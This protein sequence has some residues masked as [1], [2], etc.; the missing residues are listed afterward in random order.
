MDLKKY[1]LGRREGVR[2]LMAVEK[3]AVA[4]ILLTSLLILCFAG[5]MY[6]PWIMLGQR[7]GILAM[8]FVLKRIY[9]KIPCRLFEIVRLGAQL[10]LL[11]FWYPETY[12]FNKL[13]PNLDHIFASADQVLFACQPS[14]IFHQILSSKA[15]SEAFFM[16]YWSYY[17]M[18]VFVVLGYYFARNEK[19]ERASFVVVAS[20]FIYYIIYMFLPVAGPQYYFPA[21][22]SENLMAANFPKLGHYFATHSALPELSGY[23]QGIFHDMVNGSQAAG[24]RPTAAFPSSHVGISTI[25]MILAW[26]LNRKVT[27]AVI[28]FYILLCGATVYIRAHYLIDVFGGWI[29]AVAIFFITDRLYTSL[30][31]RQR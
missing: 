14:V 1:L 29:S 21:I 7:A 15:W 4:Y 20:F 8:V 19:F 25:V 12:E 31:R 24:E 28:P 3:A 22:G 26:K 18:M 10:G 11:A 6:H 23:A 5:K 17:P 13:F 2:G 16:G 30:I 9:E 27:I